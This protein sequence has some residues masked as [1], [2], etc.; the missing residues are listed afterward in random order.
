MGGAWM[1]W[2]RW[3]RQIDASSREC[4]GSTRCKKIQCTRYWLDEIEIYEGVTPPQSN[5][6]RKQTNVLNAIV[7]FEVMKINVLF[8]LRKLVGSLVCYSPPPPPSLFPFSREVTVM[9]KEY[10]IHLLLVYRWVMAVTPLLTSA[11]PLPPPPPF[12]I[13]NYILVFPGNER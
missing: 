12:F 6:G 4:S 9:K 3:K 13:V 7:M 5:T 11:L 8:S 2:L 1:R 10:L